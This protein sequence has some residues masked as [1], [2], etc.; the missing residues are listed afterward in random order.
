MDDYQTGPVQDSGLSVR[1]PHVRDA[2]FCRSFPKLSHSSYILRQGERTQW[3]RKRL[4]ILVNDFISV[5]FSI[6]VSFVL[7]FQ[8]FWHFYF[9]SVYEIVFS[10]IVFVLILVVVYENNLGE[11]CTF[12]IHRPNISVSVFTYLRKEL[13]KMSLWSASDQDSPVSAVSQKN[14]RQGKRRKCGSLNRVCRTLRRFLFGA[15]CARRNRCSRCWGWRS[16]R[17]A[18]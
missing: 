4:F 6:T 5:S 3:L 17:R 16:R 7:V 15:F 12:A 14:R 9:I 13:F 2:P 18:V 8:I 10:S 11:D 1:K